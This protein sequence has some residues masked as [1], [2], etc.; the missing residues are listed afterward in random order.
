[1]IIQITI[2]EN[3]REKLLRTQIQTIMRTN[4]DYPKD[5]GI[6]LEVNNRG[7]WSDNRGTYH[8]N[9]MSLY[10]TRDKCYLEAKFIWPYLIC[11]SEHHMKKEE[12]SQFSLPGSNVATFFFVRRNLKRRSTILVRNDTIYRAIDLEKIM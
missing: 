3:Q 1:M 12:M 7:I 5:K 4:A 11:I 9:I 2:L 10:R 8:Q 6:E